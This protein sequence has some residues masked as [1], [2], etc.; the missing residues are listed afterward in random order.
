M[1]GDVIVHTD[2]ITEH[3]ACDIPLCHGLCCEEGDAGAP[4]TSDE[5]DAIKAQLPALW[6]SLSNDAKEEILHNGACCRDPEGELVTAV[7]HGRDCAYRSPKG[8][9][10]SPRPISCL[11][12]PVREGRAGA[13]PTL[14]L[15][16]R[17]ICEPARL[18]GEREGTPVYQF[19][20][21]ALVRRFGRAWY[22]DLDSLAR[23]FY[24]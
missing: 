22:D 24:L 19:V 18:R 1:V 2:I 6:P 10:L 14:S 5:A 23:Q 15:Q 3:F 11:L 9:L 21:E 16:R 4:L 8:C 7:V 13:Y 17:D 20:R 12:F